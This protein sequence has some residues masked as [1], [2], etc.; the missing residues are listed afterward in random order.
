MPKAILITQCLQND[1]VRLLDKY[2]PLPNFLHIGYDEANRLLSGPKGT[3]GSL[4]Q[5]RRILKAYTGLPKTERMLF[6]KLVDEA[7]QAFT[8]EELQ[9]VGIDDLGDIRSADALAVTKG[10]ELFR[11]YKRLAVRD[12]QRVLKYV[13]QNETRFTAEEMNKVDISGISPKELE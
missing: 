2:D 1:F 4:L 3:T 11:A 9:A 10:L 13:I 5:I 8:K 6:Q 12:R 7:E